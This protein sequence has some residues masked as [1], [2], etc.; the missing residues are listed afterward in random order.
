MILVSI[1]SS[2][3]LKSAIASLTQC[4][5]RDHAHQN[6]RVNAVCPNEVDTP[7]LRTGF[8]I[9]GLDPD[10]AINELNQSV[11]IE[12]EKRSLQA[13]ADAPIN[14]L[15]KRYDLLII[16]HPWA[17]FAARTNVILSLDQYLPEAF[18]KDLATNSV[19]EWLR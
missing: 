15:A 10:N 6:I 8:A 13:F 5:G 3:K 2:S 11:D 4:L 17:G 16:D 14:E 1:L 18:I 7:M 12:W 19:T 9:R